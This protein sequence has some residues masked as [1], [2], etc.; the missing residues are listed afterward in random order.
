M[1][2]ETDQDEL[3]FEST[4]SYQDSK[5]LGEMKT[6]YQEEEE[7]KTTAPAM[8]NKNSMSTAKSSSGPQGHHFSD[9]AAQFD[10][11]N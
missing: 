5:N 8:S 10:F 1:K 11:M 2:E 6:S 9:I 3:L 7:E 4:F